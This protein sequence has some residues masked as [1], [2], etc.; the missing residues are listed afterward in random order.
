MDPCFSPRALLLDMDGLMVD[1]EPL[2]FEVERAFVRSRGPFEW[3]REQWRQCIGC[4]TRFT[5]TT[6][7]EAFGFEVDFVRDFDAIHDLFVARVAELELMPGCRELVVELHGK[8]PMAVASS[9]PRKLVE[10]VVDRFEMRPR[11]DAIVTG[12]DVERPKP[13]P[14]IFLRAADKLGV[15]AKDC[16]VLEDSVAGARAARAAGMHVICVPE[17]DPAGRGFDEV[18]SAIEKDLFAARKRM[19]IERA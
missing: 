15:A 11:F 7:S 2:W 18:A 10:A 17:G 14:D 13:A 19:V 4:G 8:I 12:S 3:T 16:L 5:L 9:S 6:M 1:S